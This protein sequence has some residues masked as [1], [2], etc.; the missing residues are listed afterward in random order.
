METAVARGLRIARRGAMRLRATRM[1][2]IASGMPWP[3]L[4]GEP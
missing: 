1:V 2:S 3:R 4:D